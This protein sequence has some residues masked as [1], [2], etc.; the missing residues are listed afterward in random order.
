MPTLTNPAAGYLQ[1]CNATPFLATGGDG[2]LDPADFPP[3]MAPEPDNN[4]ARQ[5]RLLLGGD[6]RIDFDELVR[7]TWDTRVLEADTELPVLRQELT[8]RDLPP[9]RARRALAALDLLERWDR[10]SG[11][12]S[13]QM[14]LYFFW[15]F[16][17]RE[18]HVDD[19]VAALEQTLDYLQRTYGGWRVP[20]GDV[21]RLQRSHSS[22]AEPFDDAAESLPVAGGPGI[23]FGMIFSCYARP[24]DGER[25]MYGIAGHSY[26]AV[27]EFAAPLRAR[28][29]MV[30]GPQADPAAPHY[31]DQSRLFASGR[32]KPA[33]F[34]R[35]EVAA[36]RASARILHF[37]PERG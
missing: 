8:A 26:V 35:A 24:R 3:Y 14:T 9:E 16:S 23:P 32:Y 10:R 7:L 28:S 15:R 11:V 37:W 34:G 6:R 2:N 22:G 21:N 31:F 12:D 36:N 18:R 25:R 4:R 30:F 13:P 1:N 33:W 27:V 29:V 20:W 17:M 5:S 19:P